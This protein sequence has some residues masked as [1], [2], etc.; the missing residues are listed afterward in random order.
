MHPTV[1][2]VALIADAIRD[3]SNRR[4]IVLDPFGGSGSTLVAAERTSRKARLIEI[5]ARY[6]DTIVRRWQSLTGGEAVDA[7]SG[8]TFNQCESAANRRVFRLFWLT[9][10]LVTTLSA[11]D[12]RIQGLLRLYPLPPPRRSIVYNW[13]GHTPG[14]PIWRKLSRQRPGS[15]MDSTRSSKEP[16]IGR[17]QS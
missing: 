1:K 16:S 3:C 10:R 5:D 2:P 14:S 9:V 11:T 13:G 8:Q 15:T 4:S 17:V 7:S 12:L 6:A